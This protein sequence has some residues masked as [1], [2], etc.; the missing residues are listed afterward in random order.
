[1]RTPSRSLSLLTAA[2]LTVGVLPAALAT[3]TDDAGETSPAAVDPRLALTLAGTHK[4]GQ[5]DESAAEITS[6]D[7]LTRRIFVV[8]ALKGAIDILDGTDP[9]AP[10]FVETLAA[11]GAEAADGSVVPAGATINSVKVHGEWIAVAVEAPDKVAH[12]WALFYS[13]DG[14]YL[15]GVRVGSLPDAITVSPDGTKVVVANE[16]E[17]ADDFSS[18]PEG[19][20]S[21]IDVA[22]PTEISQDDVRTAR[23]TGYDQGTELPEGVRVFGPDVEVPEGHEPAGR[24]ARNLEPEFS[25]ISADSSQ[26]FVS[27]QEANAIATIDLETAEVSNLWAIPLKDWSAEG[28]LLDT[29]NRDGEGGEGIGQ[30]GSHTF[31]FVGLERIGGVMTFDVTDPADVRFVDYVNNRNWDVA[32]DGE[33]VEGMGD[34]GAEGVEFVAAE[35]SPTGEPLVIVANE[36]SGSTSVFTVG[37]Q[38]VD[39]VAGADRYET[40]VALS[41]QF[42]NADSDTVFLTTGQAYPDALVAAARAGIQDAPVLL[43]RGE[44]LSSATRT[45]LQRLA[46]EQVVIVGGESAL[47]PAI[48]TELDELGFSTTRHAGENR[49]ETA[50]AISGEYEAGGTVYLASGQAYPDALVGSAAAGLEDAPVLLT[51]TDLLPQATRTALTSLDPSE[52]IVLGG[53]DAVS[54]EV[55]AQAAA[56][57]GAPATRV[58]GQDR[59]ETATLLAERFQPLVDAVFVASGQDYPDALTGAAVAGARRLPILLTRPDKLTEVTGATLDRLDPQRI[60]VLGGPVAVADDVLDAMEQYLP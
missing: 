2:A 49:Y 45:E 29:S 42:G 17:P 8:N 32:V 30:V 34:L 58:G 39:R 6:F 4:T 28:N 54:E 15:G 43:T 9:S 10:S 20:V 47:A 50:A 51:R 38:S 23:F 41:Q 46:P 36:V 53:T 12:G 11:E 48:A 24:V 19:T 7:P 25:A 57:T 14:D 13:T 33:Y 3:P 60:I 1:M 55:A 35:D 44:A 18:D 16:G 52:I 27:L 5:F 59:Y 22:D 40:A 21:V 37:L 31:A 56:A 26:A